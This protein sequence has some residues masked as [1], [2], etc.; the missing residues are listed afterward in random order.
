MVNFQIKFHPHITESGV[1]FE[2]FVDGIYFEKDLYYIMLSS[3]LQEDN[4]MGKKLTLDE[5][6]NSASLLNK[7]ES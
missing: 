5:R 3:G 6:I 2:K 7:Q 4:I 1:Y